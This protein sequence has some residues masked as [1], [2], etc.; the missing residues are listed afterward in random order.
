MPRERWKDLQ[1]LKKNRR[2]YNAKRKMEG[3]SMPRKVW[4]DCQCQRACGRICN[5]KRRMEGSPMPKPARRIS[6]SKG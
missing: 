4:Q 3:S 2:I 6:N 1:C 5:A